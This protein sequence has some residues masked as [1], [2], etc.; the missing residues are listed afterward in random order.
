[1]RITN[2]TT[3]KSYQLI[4]GTQLEVERPNLFFNEW[5]EQTLP[6]DIPSSDYNEEALGHPDITS[7]RKLPDD[8]Q[9]TISSGE[10]FSTCRQA[11]LKVKRKKTIS[12][13]FYLNEG[14][15]LS[16]IS[17][18]PL[19]EIFGDEKIP[20]ITTVQQ[21]INFCKSLVSNENAKFAIF[22]VVVDFDNGRRYINLMEIMDA[23][24]NIVGSRNGTLDF[25]NVYGR[26]EEVD[27]ISIKLDPGYYMSPFIRAPYLLRRLFSYFGYTLLDNFFDTTEPFKSMVFINNTIDTLVNGPILLAHLVPDCMSNTILNVFRKKFM[28]EFVPDEVNRTVSIE[29]FTDIAKLKAETDLTNYLTSPLEYDIPEYQ[30]VSLSSETMLAEGDT[31][32]STSAIKAKYPN[33]CWDPVTGS[34]CRIGYSDYSWISQKISSATIPYM[35]GGTLK[36]K[37]ISCPDAMF[38]LLLESSAN[39]GL[40]SPSRGRR[41]LVYVPYIGDGQALNSSLI[42]NGSSND[43][44]D[45]NN[46]E[47]LAS[48]KDQA[49][50]LSL[51]YKHTDGY[52]IG[53][54]TNYTFNK[55][56][57]ADYS[58][59]YNGPDGI[60]EKFY[61]T[62]DNMLRNSMH[63]VKGDILLSDH[64][65]MNI[66]PHRK[67]I[68][69]GQEMFIDKLKYIIGGKNEPIESSFYTTRLYDP[70]Q[71]AQTEGSRFP[72]LDNA[73]CWSVNRQS[74]EISEAEYNAELIKLQEER[75][76]GNLPAI[77]PPFPSKEQVAAGKFYYERSYAFYSDERNGVRHF[78]RVV[79]KLL[80][81]KTP[82]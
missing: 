63:P 14:S 22:P 7:M 69:D 61:R 62:Y 5:G 24:G 73:I 56:K 15:F 36:E 51:M 26:I 32:D 46:E 38:S 79:S 45:N 40:P 9:A 12:T 70:I 76:A 68:I 58:L 20:G 74:K 47:E 17:K 35:A 8:I 37:K 67:V 44:D 77:F 71:I 16:K 30:K 2:S 10:Y 53:T 57:F 78:Y 75:G 48:N 42:V 39:T 13:S 65:K 29:F 19:R 80:P 55:N 18:V 23:Y 6:V 31:Y 4:P 64:Q 49:P 41:T 81:I 28:C 60:Y 27:G 34:Y 25:Y 33:A 59:L 21:G 50:M 82:Y 66:P 1:M 72:T 52:C 43:E 3:G 11:I 54:N